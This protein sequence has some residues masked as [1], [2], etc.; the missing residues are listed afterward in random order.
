MNETAR[1]SGSGDWLHDF[2][3]ERQLSE[4]YLLLDHISG[5]AG[6]TLKAMQEDDL[7]EEI[8]R[9]GWP[10]AGGPV[11][12]AQQATTLLRAR[13]RLNDA[14]SPATGASIA[15][16]L[17]VM[18]DDASDGA[19]APVIAGLGAPSRASLAHTAFPNLAR[20][21]VAFRRRSQFITMALLVWL[22]LTCLL[23]WNIAS[24]TAILARIDS[25]TS[26][27]TVLTT[28]ADTIDAAET[29]VI[30]A[31]PP[32]GDPGG[33]CTRHPRGSVQIDRLCTALSSNQLARRV[34]YG[35]LADWL[36]AW[37]SL[38]WLPRA[39]VCHGDCL[40]TGPG[41]ARL[42]P[43]AMDEQWASILTAVLANAVLPVCYGILGAGAAIVRSLWS[44][45]RD[46]LL[47]P[48]DLTLSIEQLA[49]GAVV[50]ACIGLFVTP[51]NTPQS[52]ALPSLVGAIAMPASALSF[53]GGFGV[54]SVFVALEA[55]IRRV[56]AIREGTDYR[57]VADRPS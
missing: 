34:A 26:D 16:T 7:L 35:N 20:P 5:R 51:A 56:F 1:Q 10:P 9:I 40:A 44:R 24:G 39:L 50:G 29:R 30:E 54:E 3:F 53:V 38:K 15:F 32:S 23:S 46:S 19:A 55:L 49:L 27:Q 45:M 47:S 36:A 28:R 18:A 4:I 43:N 2:I 37:R 12:K 52:S 8:C 11:E 13:D 42:T 57:S 41:E 17:L 22:L 48:R 33:F 14:A 6:K 31:V 21:A 25:L